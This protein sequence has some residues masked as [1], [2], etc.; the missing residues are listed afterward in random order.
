MTNPPRKRGRPKL[1]RPPKIA[2]RPKAITPG[3][4]APRIDFRVKPELL[5]RLI[6][7]AAKNGHASPSAAARSI[8][9]QALD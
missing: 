2:R 6:N 8:L 1:D 4:S 3:Q 5:K 7:F 9:E